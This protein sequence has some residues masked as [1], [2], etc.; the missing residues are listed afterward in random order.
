MTYTGWYLL[1]PITIIQTMDG[2]RIKPEIHPQFSWMR[3]V[4]YPLMAVVDMLPIRHPILV[5]GEKHG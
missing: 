3:F 1:I 2:S 4:L 5:T